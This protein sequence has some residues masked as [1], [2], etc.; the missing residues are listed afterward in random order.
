MISGSHWR[1]RHPRFDSFCFRKGLCGQANPSKTLAASGDSFRGPLFNPDSISFMTTVQSLLQRCESTACRVCGRLGL[2][3][4]LD[5][6]LMPPSDGLLTRHQLTQTEKKLPL[7]VG[8]CSK[9]WRMQL[10]E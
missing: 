3:P 7:D 10:L 1:S 5:V 2:Q 8:F 9:W 4:V 6:G